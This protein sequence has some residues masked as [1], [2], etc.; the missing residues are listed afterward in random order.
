MLLLIYVLISTYFVIMTMGYDFFMT[1][2]WELD[3]YYYSNTP[4]NQS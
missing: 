2:K 4:Y 1:I 3:V